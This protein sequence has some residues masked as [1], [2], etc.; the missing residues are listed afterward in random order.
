[1]M[2]VGEKWQE[3]GDLPGIAG[4]SDTWL[5]LEGLAYKENEL[6]KGSLCICFKIHNSDENG[7]RGGGRIQV[8]LG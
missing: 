3:H 7:R 6:E 8:P 1:M 2:K 4:C 5:A